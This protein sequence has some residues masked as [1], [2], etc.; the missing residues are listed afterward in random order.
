MNTS[1]LVVDDDDSG[2]NML[3]L[4]MRQAGF[5]VQTAA[6]GEE[7]LRLLQ[8][9]HFDWLITDARM[10]PMDGFKLSQKAK[11]IQ[12][13]LHIVMIS[14]LYTERS[15]NGHPIEKLF[16]KPVSIEELIGWISGPQP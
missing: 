11:R 14:A 7:A 6:S 3:A 1:L 12:P 15:V 5:S 2:R 13:D 4:S 10:S 16:T 8:N 9:T